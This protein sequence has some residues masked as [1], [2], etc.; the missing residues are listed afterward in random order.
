MIQ[1]KTLHG[2][3]DDPNEEIMSHP[4]Y[5]GLIFKPPKFP[6]CPLQKEFFLVG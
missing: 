3:R 5:T 1:E 2:T 4:S 6:F